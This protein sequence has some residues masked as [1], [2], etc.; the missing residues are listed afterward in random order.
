M[1]EKLAFVTYETPY[2]PS[3]GIAAVMG[4]IVAPVSQAMGLPTCVI[5]PYHYRVEEM[6]YLRPTIVG[7][8]K[9]PFDD[10]EVLVNI[11]R[12]RDEWLT[13]FLLPEDPAFFAGK[14]HP[15]DV[16]DTEQKALGHLRR[17]ALFFGDAVARSLHIIAPGATWTLL[18]QDWQAA[19]TALFTTD[20]DNVRACLLTLHNSY[21]SGGVQGGELR[22]AGLEPVEL[23]RQGLRSWN[24]DD[25]VLQMALHSQKMKK[26]V[27]TVSQQFARDL[28]ED[29]LESQVMADHLQELLR[30]RL[31][32][33]DNGL[34]QS[35]ALPDP[36]WEAAETGDYGPLRS[37]KARMKA[38]SLAAL[39]TLPTDDPARPIWGD[40]TA[41]AA[42]DPEAPAPWFVF[43]GRDDTRQKG[44]D[45]AVAAIRQFLDSGGR[46]RFLFFPMP[47]DEGLE[48]LGFLEELARDQPCSVIALPF[49]FEKIQEAIR[50]A[51]F[52]VMPSFYEPFGMANEFYL[53][54]TAGIGRA[55]GGIV[56][57]LI[58]RR[59]VPVYSKAVEELDLRWYPKGDE[60]TGI[61]YRE[62]LDLPTVVQDW[63]VINQAAYKRSDT[64]DRL[65]ERQ[66][67]PLFRSMVT[68]LVK[69]FDCAGQIV[70]NTFGPDE[71]FAMVTRGLRHMLDRFSWETT[72]KLYAREL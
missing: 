70:E 67:L 5:T 41:F 22:R 9:V 62:P 21:D 44:L 50:G 6:Q 53:N 8:V 36:V 23:R 40:P 68:E 27:F 29:P 72:A 52:G 24:G 54:G 11:C 63:K 66:N 25:T 28:T 30:D 38:N 32:G 48:G 43:A 2:A 39:R 17:D 60:P 49:R 12:V 71:Y 14:R 56:Q 33:A 65:C 7:C 51:D 34:F 15:Y 42:D 20:K 31:S 55:T 13:H 61:L 3:G 59:D 1:S 58:P 57:Q 69:A 47:G 35:L 37:W 10:R 19:T 16:G 45:V 64:S 26:T 4:R 46:G 18:L